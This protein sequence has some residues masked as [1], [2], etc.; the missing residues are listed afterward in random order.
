MV[1]ELLATPAVARRKKRKARF[2]A[3]RVW[4][5]WCGGSRAYTPT[6]PDKHTVP[7][8]LSHSDPCPHQCPLI[9]VSAFWPFCLPEIATVARWLASPPQLLSPTPHISPQISSKHTHASTYLHCPFPSGVASQLPWF[10]HDSVGMEHLR[11]A[12]SKF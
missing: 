4:L 6:R 8:S 10:K 11:P 2:K 3:A 7:H 12:D 9:T 5:D 1:A